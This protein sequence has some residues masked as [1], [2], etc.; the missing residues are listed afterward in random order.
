MALRCFK[1][2]AVSTEA[3]CLTIG[4]LQLGLLSVNF[5]IVWLNFVSSCSTWKETFTYLVQQI[6]WKPKILLTLTYTI[7]N[8]FWAWNWQIKKKRKETSKE[9]SVHQQK[10]MPRT[11]TCPQAALW[12]LSKYK[13]LFWWQVEGST[14]M[15]EIWE[16][17]LW[18]P[19]IL[20]ISP[21]FKTIS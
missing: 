12:R 1:G 19:S 4:I 10:I 3:S 2:S 14:E 15:S 20:R 11:V 17:M 13:E 5:R 18:V 8:L 6:K 16:K 7:W 9:I 21:Y